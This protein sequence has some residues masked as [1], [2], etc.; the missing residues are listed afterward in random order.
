VLNFVSE[1]PYNLLTLQGKSPYP[2]I[3]WIT[4]WT[5]AAAGLRAP[6]EIGAFIALAIF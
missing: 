3:L 4:L 2:H 5:G 1:K 6:R